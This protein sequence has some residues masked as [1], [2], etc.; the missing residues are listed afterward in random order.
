[1]KFKCIN[2]CNVVIYIIC[3][4]MPH[5]RKCQTEFLYLESNGFCGL[6]V[7]QSKELV[8]CSACNKKF[9]SLNRNGMCSPCWAKKDWNGKL[10]E[11]CGAKNY[12]ASIVCEKCYYLPY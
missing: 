9:Y 10:C 2:I 1:M 11:R 5:C 7:L 4:D 8:E 6:C 12:T 3:V